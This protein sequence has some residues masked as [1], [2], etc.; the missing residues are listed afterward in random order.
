MNGHDL[1]RRVVDHLREGEGPTRLF[2]L[3][4][5]EAGEGHARVSMSVTAAM[6]NGVGCAHGGVIFTLADT[7][8][9]YACNS[10][11]IAN[12]AQQASIAF[13]NP[14]FE[15]ERLVADAREVAVEGRT[16]VY[17]VTVTSADGR[18]IASFN[19]LS[20][21]LGRALVEPDAAPGPGL[22]RTVAAPS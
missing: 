14:A 8:F 10:R 9:A 11:N 16:G 13:L 18:V 20:R 7:A 21:T 19:G 12:V 3:A 5:E 4:L 15:G 2:D 1:A 6:L 22:A 17:G